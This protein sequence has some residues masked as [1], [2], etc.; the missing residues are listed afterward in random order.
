MALP[1]SSLFSTKQNIPVQLQPTNSWVLSQY[2]HNPERFPSKSGTAPT[3]PLHNTDPYYYPDYFCSLSLI[4][5]KP[6]LPCFSSRQFP[7]HC[8]FLP[9]FF[10]SGMHFLWIFP[11]LPLSMPNPIYLSLS[12]FKAISFVK[13]FTSAQENA[14]LFLSNFQVTASLLLSVSTHFNLVLLLI[15]CFLPICLGRPL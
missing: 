11:H 12:S 7:R 10:S 9:L 6:H 13:I 5:V 4:L 14:W 8:N 3:I 1:S 2:S 15:V